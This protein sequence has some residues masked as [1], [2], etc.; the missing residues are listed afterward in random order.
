[1][2]R[3]GQRLRRRAIRRSAGGGAFAAGLALP[4][5]YTRENLKLVDQGLPNLLHHIGVIRRS[6]INPV[7]CINR[8]T[9]DTAEEIALV[10][11]AAEAA[12][13]GGRQPG[14]ALDRSKPK[15][16]KTAMSLNRT[17]Y[18]PI[19]AGVLAEI[20]A[21][22]GPSAGFSGIERFAF[23]EAAKQSFGVVQVGDPRPMA[24]SCCARA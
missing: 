20:R 10:R 1:L 24:A 12:G 6:G 19:D 5:E 4:E 13:P 7:V 11:R 18:R 14:P 16:R 8:F 3:P 22:L 17:H 23:Y 2:R 15:R 9:T 21:V